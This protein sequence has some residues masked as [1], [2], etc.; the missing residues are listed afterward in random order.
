MLAVSMA[1]SACTSAGSVELF[2]EV[3]TDLVAG[4]EFASVQVQ[5]GERVASAGAS[6]GDDYASG[7]RVAEFDGLAPGPAE[8]AV[9]IVDAGGNIVLRRDVSLTLEQ[10][11]GL[12]V[13]LARSCLGVECPDAGPDTV[14]TTCIDG[15]CL[16]RLCSP[17]DRAAC[18]AAE[19]IAAADCAVR[20]ECASAECVEGVCLELGVSARC[21]EA[22]YCH[23]ETGCAPVPAGDVDGDGDGVAAEADC[24]DADPRVGFRAERACSSACATG[25]EACVSGRWRACDAPVDCS[26]EGTAT[27]TLRCER[28]GT[29]TQ[30]CEGGVWVSGPCEGQGSCAPGALEGVGSCGRCGLER[31]TCLDDCS[32]DTPAC[33]GEGVC[34]AG[35]IEDEV[36]SCGSCSESRARSR[37]CD[38][39][40]A[41]SA[42]SEFGACGAST[43]CDPGEVE[44]RTQD[45]GS[46]GTQSQSRSCGSECVFGAWS[47]WSAC[48]GEGVCAPSTPRSE[49]RPC[50]SC[51][52][53]AEIRTS[54]CTSACGWS[55]WSSWSACTVPTA[56]SISAGWSTTC[57]IRS[58]GALYCWGSNENG[59]LGDG[60]T[61]SRDVPART[62]TA[63]DWTLIASD[64]TYDDALAANQGHTCGIRGGDLYCWGRDSSGQ[65]GLGAAGATSTPARVG[66]ASDWTAI[67]VG[68]DHTCGIRGAG[69]L[70]C[71]GEGHNGRLGTGSTTDQ[72]SP[73]QVGTE[74]DWVQITL[75]HEFSCGRRAGSTLF[76]WGNGYYG[77]LGIGMVA[78]PSTPQQVGGAEWASVSAGRAHT[79]AIKASG[80]LWCWGWANHGR[81]GDGS[82]TG[83]REAP[84][85][86]GT[87]SDWVSVSAGGS[88]T[89]AIR[90]SGALW[91]WG[92]NGY[93]EL[94]DGTGMGRSTPVAIGASTD[95]TAVELGDSHS[96][97][98][99]AGVLHCWGIARGR[100][101][102]G[103][104]TEDVWSPTAVCL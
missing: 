27:R 71:W 2:V 56:L 89:C 87:D 31:R 103:S 102:L 36:E 84:V 17:L 53:G 54:T 64:G 66:T 15:R 86:V 77:Q 78:Y 82:T 42:W 51:T 58:D 22:E 19:C 67:A 79:C 99:R 90:E 29:I 48:T 101:G 35:T 45:C 37:A 91:C 4:V 100:L 80:E 50:G 49:M 88:H 62:G 16:S 68:A 81:L 97:A 70:W 96:C 10:S 24:N 52:S 93:G 18:G 32:W 13:V 83:Q 26:C 21:A 1:A 69:T 28:C 43:G 14:A 55:A 44:T 98:V 30:R 20:A 104:I 75:G 46:C 72:Q 47:A 63:S 40:C 74:T 59:M 60:S 6:L 23:P 11:L 34:E 94:G 95:W 76:C 85:R 8:I 73:V 61:S 38:A 57:G 5:L 33:V 92:R 12:A 41:W 7:V 39:S 9:S 25:I 3:Q 65:L